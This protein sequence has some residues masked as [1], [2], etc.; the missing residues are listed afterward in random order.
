MPTQVVVD[1]RVYNKTMGRVTALVVVVFLLLLGIGSYFYFRTKPAPITPS[2]TPQISLTPTSASSYCQPNDLSTSIDF[3]GAA[4]SIY[5]NLIIKNISGKTC[6]IDG[7][8]YIEASTSATNVTVEKQGNPGPALLV[9]SPNQSAY[10]QIRYE[11]G[12]QCSSPIKNTPTT[13]GYEIS[14]G[15][16]V[17]FK[18]QSG[19]DSQKITTCTNQTE[20]TMIWV[21][22]LSPN[23]I[24]S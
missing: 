17:V 20:N 4:G 15:I 3:S 13:F 18:D 16:R 10:S 7:N 21:W 22:N 1:W 9:L 24:S 2:P 8:N 11:N 19:S 5:G 6:N 23:P 14:P 12:P